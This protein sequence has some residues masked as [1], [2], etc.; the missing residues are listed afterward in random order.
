LWQTMTMYSDVA[1][2]V[3]A[4][5][6]LFSSLD[7]DCFGGNPRFGAPGSNDVPRPALISPLEGIIGGDVGWR[8]CCSGGTSDLGFP[9]Q[10]MATHGTVLSRGASFLE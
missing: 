2:F 4:L 1:T 8:C 6:L 9:D 3:K 10:T 7:L 5:S